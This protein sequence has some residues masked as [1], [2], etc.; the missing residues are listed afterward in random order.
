M[1]AHIA[2]THWSNCD[3]EEL[4]P[5]VTWPA[6]FPVTRTLADVLPGYTV[7]FSRGTTIVPSSVSLMSSPNW[8]VNSIVAVSFKGELRSKHKACFEAC[9]NKL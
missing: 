4:S 1:Y 7:M 8:Y 3:E 5:R 9:Y 2:F 6:L